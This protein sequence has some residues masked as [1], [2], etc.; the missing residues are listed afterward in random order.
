MKD[1][2]EKRYVSYRAHEVAIFIHEANPLRKALN[3][4]LHTV[5][6][7]AT[8]GIELT[9]PTIYNSRSHEINE[10]LLTEL[11]QQLPKP[12]FLTVDIKSYHKCLENRSN[13][14]RGK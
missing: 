10:Q 8:M 6:F 3:T 14:S 2:L 1:C 11:I 7:T 5:A 9:V 4:P 12:I 13:D